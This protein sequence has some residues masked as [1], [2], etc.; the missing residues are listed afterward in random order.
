[1]WFLFLSSKHFRASGSCRIKVKAI[2]CLSLRLSWAFW[3]KK[4]RDSLSS[5]NLNKGIEN[6]REEMLNDRLSATPI[7]HSAWRASQT[8]KCWYLNCMRQPCLL[9]WERVLQNNQKSPMKWMELPLLI[10]KK[11]FLAVVFMTV[12]AVARRATIE[13]IKSF[14]L[15][16]A[17]FRRIR[18]G[19]SPLCLDR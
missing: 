2:S 13:R 5:F 9:S 1:M 15:N 4:K 8:E 10:V 6:E 18:R 17:F 16:K 14:P 12:N 7:C 19:L 3:Q 11:T